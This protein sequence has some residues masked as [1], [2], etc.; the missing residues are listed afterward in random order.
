MSFWKQFG[1]GLRS[2]KAAFNYIFTKG[3]WWFLIFP[4]FINIFLF[5]GGNTLIG[6]FIELSKTTVLDWTSLNEMEFWGS[7]FLIKALNFT[8][9]LLLRF[10]FFVLFAYLGGYV[11]IIIMSPVFAYLSELTEKIKQAAEDTAHLILKEIGAYK[12]PPHLAPGSA[13][14]KAK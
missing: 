6:N 13:N 10:M 4:L 5:L 11:V 12:F 2:Y 14:P 9:S 8:I 3:L 7:A 1:I